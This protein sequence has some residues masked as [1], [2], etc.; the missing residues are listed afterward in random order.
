MKINCFFLSYFPGTEILNYALGH[1]LLSVE[2]AERFKHGE[3]LNY[4]QGGSLPGI[5]PETLAIARNYEKLFILITLVPKSWTRRIIEKRSVA[6]LRF[7]PSIA[8]LL[9]EVV[10]VF[11]RRNQRVLAY[12]KY[13]RT[14]A[15]RF[16][17]RKFR[18]RKIEA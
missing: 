15:W 18:H 1:E 3:N 12:M 2:Q 10:L 17:K 5:A 16:L 8:T 7:I 6:S 13:Y 9:I 4:Y 14:H 11:F